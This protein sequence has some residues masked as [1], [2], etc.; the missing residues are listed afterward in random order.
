MLLLFFLIAFLV[1]WSLF[2]GAS[3]LADRSGFSTLAELM[4]FLGAIS[5]GLVAIAMTAASRGREG[6]KQL[7]SK[8][9]FNNP[10]AGWYIFALTFIALIK[11]LAALVFFVIYHTWPPFGTTPWYMMLAALA[12]STWVQ[13]GEEIGWRGYALPLMSKKFG[14]ALS[15]VL[16]GIIWAAWHLPLFYLAAADTFNQSFPLYLMQVTGL[17]VIM[18][19]LLWKV[20]GNLLPLM[21]FHAA[22]NN[23]KDIVPSL[24]EKSASPFNFN[25]SPIGWIT[26]VLI[27]IV[28]SYV[29]YAMTRKPAAK[30]PS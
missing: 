6:V 8:I 1:A 30:L 23:T 14:L 5:P 27:W 12:V 2:I 20:K 3:L 7:V 17:S 16:L 22:I 29:L 21:V 28:A 13:A 11:G 10:G 26:V 24:S 18:A 4:V 25:A 9:S 19:W 15:G